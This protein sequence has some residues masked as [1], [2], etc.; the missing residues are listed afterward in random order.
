MK[1]KNPTLCINKVWGF[2][3][4]GFCSGGIQVMR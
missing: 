4:S 3:F 1:Q 2:C